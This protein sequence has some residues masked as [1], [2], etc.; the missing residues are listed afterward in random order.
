MGIMS[1]A[2][3]HRYSPISVTN[4]VEGCAPGRHCVA[5]LSNGSCTRE[6]PRRRQTCVP[7]Q[8]PMPAAWSSRKLPAHQH[9]SIVAGIA[10]HKCHT[11]TRVP[12]A[13]LLNLQRACKFVR[14]AGALGDAQ[15][16]VVLAAQQ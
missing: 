1:Q 2:M 14:L 8:V 7:I 11:C 6:G 9:H 4:D 16:V 15:D 3:A 13:H 5:G 10:A 12:A